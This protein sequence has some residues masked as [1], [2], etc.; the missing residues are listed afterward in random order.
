MPTTLEQ[1]VLAGH[2]DGGAGSV[3]LRAAMTEGY[4][5][6]Y[7]SHTLET[8]PAVLHARALCAPGEVSGG[9]AHLMGGWSVA[10]AACWSVVFDADLRRVW[11]EV[12]GAVALEAQLPAA[13]GWHTIEVK[14]NTAEGSASLII[15]GLVAGAL[16][17]ISIDGTQVAWLGVQAKS[18]AMVGSIDLDDWVI[19]DVPIG[20]RLVAPTQSHAGDPSRWLVVYNADHGDAAA[21]AEQYRAV[22]G[23]PYANLCGLS[24]PLAETITSL[25]YDALRDAVLGYLSD[26]GLAEQVVGV[27]LGLGVPGYAE[28]SG[29]GG[30]TAVSSLLHTDASG[31][32]LSLNALHRDPP[33]ERPTADLLPGLRFTGRID[34]ASLEEAHALV[35]RATALMD[36]PPVAGLGGTL[37]LDPVPEDAELNPLYTGPMSA[38]VDGPLPSKLRLPI[39]LAGDAGHDTIHDDFAFWGWGQA[40]VPPG[41][42]GSP[43][44]RR[45]VCVQLESASP[46]AN[47]QR[48]SSAT[49]W[50]RQ[51]VDAGYAAASASSR[52]YTLSALPQPSV[53]FEALRLGWTLAEAWLVCQPF[54]RN[55]MQMLGDPLLTIQT[56]RAGFDVYG[57][58][59]GLEAVDTASPTMRLPETSEGVSLA[60]VLAPADDES[61]L[62]LVR[63]V[64]GRGRCDGGTSTLRLQ[65]VGGRAATP[66]VLPAWPDVAGWPVRVIAG[67]VQAVALWA[68]VSALRDIVRVEVEADGG[69][70]EEVVW[71]GEPVGGLAHVSAVFEVPEGALRVRWRMHHADGAQGV[72]PWSAALIEPPL[73]EFGFPTFEVN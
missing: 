24:L 38:W 9:S 58:A 62:Y 26:N 56:P 48:S 69:A 51:A 10:G 6:C 19:A 23:V 2:P 57:P 43:G 54:L 8:P 67:E 70:G 39:A 13:L 65:R 14:L 7:L 27:L 52:P 71:S 61:S 50:L 40:S 18:S 37:W 30:V 21:W 22:R 32:A 34:G 12:P 66:P 47:Q 49:H 72:S 29:L 35:D 20:P 73:S 36:G 33:T 68:S 15:N 60:G 55:G 46:A 16:S 1:T 5:G 11:L 44:G 41:F 4:G 63:R 45:G 64:D 59:A 28:T 31:D 17:G 3:G 42:F 53:F 25:Q